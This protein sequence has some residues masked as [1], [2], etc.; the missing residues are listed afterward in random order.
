MAQ[1]SKSSKDSS[2]SETPTA[3]CGNC[4]QLQRVRKNGAMYKHKCIPN[5]EEE[6]WIDSSDGQEA[7][8]THILQN[9]DNGHIEGDP[10][11][12]SHIQESQSG[13][14]D[15]VRESVNNQEEL[16]HGNNDLNSG[17]IVESVDNQER[18]SGRTETWANRNI[19]AN[20]DI[21]QWA[22]EQ[23][24]ILS[25]IGKLIELQRTISGKDEELTILLDKFI[26]NKHPKAKSFDRVNSINHY[27][28]GIAEEEIINDDKDSLSKRNIISN[29]NQ[30]IKDNKLSS[31]IR[32]LKSKG[33]YNF[34]DNKS[35]LKKLVDLFPNSDTMISEEMEEN[36]NTEVDIPE[37][38]FNK[39][40]DSGRKFS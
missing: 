18:L 40:N 28:I 4:R 27:G 23:E 35:T 39:I 37:E 26:N 21:F 12:L 9:V 29:I 16:G 15:G 1:N 25:Q 5:S 30:H 33:L 19:R 13:N 6:V 2:S 20:N 3:I 17:C 10:S 32:I 31:A 24:E 8:Q 34:A 22:S 36:D 7:F 14:G 38:V 11:Q